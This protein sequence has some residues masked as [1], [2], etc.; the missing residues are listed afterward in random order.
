MRA[1][2]AYA[3]IELYD[4]KRTP[5]AV[6][7]S[8]NTN[9]FGVAPEVRQLFALLPDGLVT[10]YPPVFAEELKQALA[11]RH[12]VAAEN[13]TTGCGSDDVID[14]TL[15]AYCEPRDSVAYPVPTFG[16]IPT[17]ARM[18][19][20]A[21]VAVVS[22]ADFSINVDDIIAA[23][24][25][26]TYVC[27]PNNP[28][29]TEVAAA[30]IAR[31]DASL[32][33]LLLLDEAYADFSDVDYAAFAVQS[34][35]TVSLRT[36]SKACGLAGMRV[37]YAIGPAAIIHEIEKSRGPYKV[38]AL[39]DAAA[40]GILSAD[41]AWVDDVVAQT[42]SNRARLLERLERL[43]LTFWP[44]AANFIL[45]KL[46]NGQQAS[47]ANAALR[48]RGVAIR[49]FPAVP[50]AGECIRV[51]VG[52]WPMMETFLTALSAVL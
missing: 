40:R 47:E 1:R 44:S 17:F 38:S 30:D 27:S 34:Q 37:G 5:C 23:R 25:R 7:L 51:T 49:P 32:A 12:G 2:E 26:V 8:D 42:R 14:S 46:P 10:R 29:G 6:D 13:I 33:G 16:V 45:I 43:D 18:N 50:H 20:A 36:M 35:R 52:P 21:P 48:A 15:R 22:N 28:T 19:A 31:L 41:T 4:P 24:A 3:A 39:A 9:L 11:R